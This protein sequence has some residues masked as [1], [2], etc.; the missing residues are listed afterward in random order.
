MRTIEANYAARGLSVVAVNLDH[1]R[2][3]ADTFLKKFQPDFQIR[4]DPEGHWAQ[5]FGVQGM[6]T[7]VLID[8][9]GVVRFTHIGFRLDDASKYTRQIEQLLAEH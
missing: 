8:R 7:S 5:Q 3:D 4:F 6:P 1:D 2:S 9:Q